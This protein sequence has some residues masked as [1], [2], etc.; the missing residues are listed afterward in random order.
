M[1]KQRILT[2]A[3]V[4]RVRTPNSPVLKQRLAALEAEFDR[5]IFQLDHPVPPIMSFTY[6][7]ECRDA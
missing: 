2:G 6:K 7:V 1:L 4:K 5:R 3:D